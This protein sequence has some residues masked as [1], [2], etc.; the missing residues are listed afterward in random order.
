MLQIVEAVLSRLSP[1]V[2]P[3]VWQGGCLALAELARR[4]ALLPD[5]LDR[6]H[7]VIQLALVYEVGEGG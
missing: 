6:L 2:G 3:S 7:G 1:T 5:Q 4:G